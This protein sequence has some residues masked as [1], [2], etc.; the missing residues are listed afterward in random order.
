MI[1]FMRRVLSF[2]KRHKHLIRNIAALGAAVLIFSIGLLLI[3][4]STW[5]VPALDSIETRKVSQSTKIY[6]RTGEILLYDVFQN[7]KRT[8]VPFDQISDNVK[9]ASL[10]IEDQDFYEH[11]GV[12]PVSFLRAVIVNVLSAN[13]TQG[14]STITQQVVKNSLL[15]G[16]KRI[17]RKLKEWVLAIKL[18][19]ILTKEQIFSMYL[20]EIP[21]GG[22]LYGVEE[23][24]QA[25]FGKKASDVT[26]A[27]AA[28]LAAVP[29]AP[30][31]YSPYGKNRERLEVRKNLVLS[32]MLRIKLITK[33]QHDAAMAE[34]ITFKPQES[35]GIKAPHFVL[36]VKDLLQKKYGDQVLEEGG[37]KVIT[38]IDYDLQKKAED[39]ARDYGKKNEK[40]VDAENVAAVAIDPKTGDIRAMVGS[41]DYFDKEID[42]NFNITTA[43]RQPGSTFK[44][45]AYAQAFVKGF[46]PETT[47]FD[48]Q[49]EFSTTCNPDGTPRSAG[50][51]CYM[52]QNYDEI[53]RG[54]ITMRE[55]LAQS[56]NI[57]AIKTLYLAGLR[58]T[59]RLAKDMGIQSL[60]NTNQYGLT[61]VLGGSEVSLLDLTSAYGV[62]ANDGVRNP[63][64][65][66]LEIKDRNGVTIE[67][68][69]QSPAQVL[70]A[71]AA[72]LISNV[73][74]D[75]VARI[76]A[77]GANSPLQFTGRAVAAKT[78]TTND[79]RDAWVV[80][81]SPNIALGVWA[82]NND[83]HPMQKKVA[84]FIVAPFWNLVMKEALKTTPIDEAFVP[85]DLS[86]T[87][88]LSL[89][90]V[91]RSKWQGGISTFI[92]SITKRPVTEN[93][94]RELYE[95]V[96][97][98]GVHSILYWVDKN[99]PRGPAPQN[100]QNDSQFESWE[101]GVQKW[102]L[103]NGYFGNTSSSTPVTNNPY[104][105]DD[106]HKPEYAPQVSVLKPFPNDLYERSEKIYVSINASGRFPLLK[107]EYFLG[108]QFI[109]STNN[110][111]FLFSFIPA[112]LDNLN[113]G[114]NTLRVIVY[115]TVLNKTEVSVP[116]T[117]Q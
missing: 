109:G 86:Y 32:E 3:W 36:F 46:T 82:G 75:E 95:E 28:Y 39:I 54:P 16:E 26:L 4:A 117:I 110:F 116:I 24:A 2:V 47:L 98:G 106:I 70:P 77:V 62:F 13:F 6:D 92:D 23:A 67:K 71:E 69:T 30:T 18:E 90:P 84:R 57:P 87:S 52:P 105:D 104:G 7:I 78:G 112:D 59:L 29:K 101:Y 64:R 15:T 114:Q 60:T 72:R 65:A 96:L 43:L 53:F 56:I 100:P 73:L 38:T 1:P 115:D 42:G 8:V 94:P 34:Q 85:P 41:R 9:K 27:E 37:L 68:A 35:F 12:K 107:V 49:T 63:Y 111:P 102:A 99:D 40:D 51:N 89:K 19:N 58:E 44:P 20:N 91:L 79:Y 103:Q 97:S 80:G 21:Y 17:S 10:A 45:F 11:N 50:A 61:L 55:A 33:E 22:S 88:D 108:S 74:S 48:L 31:Y 93:T 76:P 81:Y 66:I 83:N 5:R 25:F 14:G 113:I